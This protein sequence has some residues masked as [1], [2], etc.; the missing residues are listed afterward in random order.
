[1]R[2]LALSERESRPSRSHESVD[3]DTRE[4]GHT[5]FVGHCNCV[6][7]S[8]NYYTTHEITFAQFAEI[9]SI[10]NSKLIANMCRVKI[11]SIVLV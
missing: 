2:V 1:M 3:I 4:L 7:I 9:N 11:I 10:F 5:S 8:V 6:I